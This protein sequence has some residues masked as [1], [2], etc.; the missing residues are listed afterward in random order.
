MTNKDKYKKVFNVLTASEEFVVEVETLKNKKKRNHRKNI[1]AAVAVCIVAGTAGTGVYAAMRHWGILDFAVEN[2]VNVPEE[3]AEYIQREINT[4]QDSNETI[5]ECTVKEG[6]ADSQNITVV[7]EVSAKEANK[8]LFIPADAMPENLMSEWYDNSQ[9]TAGKYAEEKGLTIVRIGGGISNREELGIAVETVAFK[10]VSDDIMD[11]FVTCGKTEESKNLPV[12]IWATAQ[13]FGNENIMKL[14]SEFELQSLS[15]TACVTYGNETQETEGTFFRIEK[16]KVYQTELRTYLELYYSNEQGKNLN[17][18]LSFRLVD[19]TGK[20]YN[21]IG[22]S[23][24][25]SIGESQYKIQ[26][27]F[28]KCEMNDNLYIEAFDCLNGKV[29]G[30]TELS[31]QVS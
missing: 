3:A 8:Y 26:Y 30:V 25:E 2:S 27:M 17:D 31:L 10:S 1:A 22:G 19:Q 11:I 7:F 29:Y 5:F 18:G 6:L 4:I 15:E 13:I 12:E 14:Q 16:A 9:M 23:G 24:I 20:E 28:N 21:I